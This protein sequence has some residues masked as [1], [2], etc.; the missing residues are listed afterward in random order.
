MKNMFKS[1]IPITLILAVPVL[2]SAQDNLRSQTENKPPV[3]IA[4]RYLK[5]SPLSFF[6]IFGIHHE[7][8]MNGKSINYVFGYR[9]GDSESSLG[10]NNG[11]PTGEHVESQH[12]Y[13]ILERRFYGSEKDAEG[14]YWAPFFEVR[15][16]T[17]DVNASSMGTD[18]SHDRNRWR[19]N[20]GLM[21]GY[22]FKVSEKFAIDVF[23]GVRAGYQFISNVDFDRSGNQ[24]FSEYEKL[25][26]SNRKPLNRFR[27][28]VRLG[29]TVGLLIG[30][31]EY[32][33][34]SQR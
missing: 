32:Q 12:H 16:V 21:G 18:Y 33:A 5:V 3:L 13:L 17:E 8:F 31:A 34:K 29:L 26:R 25:L 11:V 7:R 10:L 2:L 6:G 27:W 30:S 1:L 19:I 23:G 20:P 4:R 14:A 15:L 9:D 22:Q 28:G 24:S